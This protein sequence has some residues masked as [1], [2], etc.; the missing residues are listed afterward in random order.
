MGLTTKDYQRAL[1]SQSAC[2][3]SGLIH[4]LNE[5]LEQIWEEAREKGE[6]TDWV[7]GHPIVRLYAE[8]LMWLSRKTDY[9]EAYRVCCE[10][11]AKEQCDTLPCASIQSE[12]T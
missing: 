3:A 8:Q 11:R 10:E 1:D 5:T 6:G 9:F 7:S 4:S 12:K 2:N